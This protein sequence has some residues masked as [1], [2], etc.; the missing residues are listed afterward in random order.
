[1][2]NSIE[3]TLLSIP[4]I[5]TTTRRTGRAEL[6]EHAQGVN[7]SEIDAPFILKDRSRD[8]F[9]EDLR[10][11][12]MNFTSLNITIG[13]PIGHRIDHMLSGTRANIA[14]KLYGEDLNKLFTTA[15]D[16]KNKIQNI[17]GLVDL[18][19]EQQIDIPQIQIKAKREM[20]ASYGIPISHFVEFI[21]VAFA[22]E[23][24]SQIFE[25]NKSY[26]LI[27]RFENP[28]NNNIESIKNTLID[29]YNGQKVPLY[30]VADIV[31]SSGPNTINRENVQ[32]KIVISTNVVGRDQKSTVEEIQKIIN[33]D[34]KLPEGYRIEYGGQFES[35]A[36]ASKTL[37]I[38]SALS[39]FIIM[40]LLYQEFKDIKMSVIVLINLP[41]A[42]IGGMFAILFT[43][44]II[45]IPSIIGF[46]TLFGIATRNGILLISR[47]N[48]L[49]EEGVDLHDRII[50]GS[51]DRLN[52]IL[53]TALAAGLALI[54]LAI[55]GEEP[56]NE[57]QSPMAK[58]ILGGLLTSTFLNLIV[59]PIVYFLSNKKSESYEL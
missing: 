33:Y 47:Y 59:V 6:D 20:L 52:P 4:E 15:N 19:V 14:I 51:L 13:Q 2:G 45:S 31:S 10:N 11:K 8:E 22:G 30:Y 48:T 29:T 58:V 50:R 46:I 35:E 24:V 53:M 1:M 16:I 26:D 5:Q 40:L 38:M 55:A 25:G 54:P 39:L 44:Q 17:E 36:E 18:S 28:S 42:L 37:L 23:K 57:I 34:V 21:D 3:Q 43:S 9:M 56:G 27:L 32:R 49:R 12:L 7:A 41:L